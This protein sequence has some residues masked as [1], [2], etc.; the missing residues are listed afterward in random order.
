[1]SHVVVTASP[2]RS[3]AFNRAVRTLWTG[4]GVDAAAAVGAGALTLLNGGDVMS[5]LFW[6]AV[7]TLAAKSIVTAFASYLVRLKF[8]PAGTV[9]QPA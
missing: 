5:P 2:V 8:T 6:T 9:D 1:M 4:F 3:D 7:G